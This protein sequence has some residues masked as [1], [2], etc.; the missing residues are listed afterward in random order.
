VDAGD[1]IAIGAAVIAGGGAA[2]AVWQARIASRG[3]DAAGRA[4]TAAETA[5]VHAAENS[6]AAVRSAAAAEKALELQRAEADRVAASVEF[7]AERE[8]DSAR[9]YFIRN[10]GRSTAFG[11]VVSGGYRCDFHGDGEPATVWPEGHVENWSFVLGSDSR[12][13]IT[14]Y[15]T[16]DTSGETNT[17]YVQLI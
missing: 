14:W 2:V 7:I 10:K 8:T 12:A 9:S 3:A 1:Y 15:P 16:E 17:S 5:N 6:A 11:V 13:R 4:A